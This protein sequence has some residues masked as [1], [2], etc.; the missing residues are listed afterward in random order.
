M[1]HQNRDQAFAQEATPSTRRYAAIN[2]NGRAKFK[3]PRSW[4]L[5]WCGFSLGCLPS[6]F[7]DRDGRGTDSESLADQTGR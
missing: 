6:A 7:G 1:N 4:A 5:N 3:E 2:D